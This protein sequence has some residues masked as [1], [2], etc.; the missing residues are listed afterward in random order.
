MKTIILLAAGVLL[1]L[2]AAA[3]AGN[4][5]FPAFLFWHHICLYEDEYALF[6]VPISGIR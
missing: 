5:A 3:A 4:R 2:L 1:L 6:P